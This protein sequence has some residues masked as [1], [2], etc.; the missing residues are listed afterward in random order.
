MTAPELYRVEIL[1]SDTFGWR[2]LGPAQGFAATYP[3]EEAAA[4]AARQ[5]DD[6]EPRHGNAWRV[7][8]VGTPTGDGR[9]ITGPRPTL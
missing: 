4:A 1:D 5:W 7:V 9:P 8:P 2:P 6:E 3:T